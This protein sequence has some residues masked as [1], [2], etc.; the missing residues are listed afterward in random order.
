MDN[1][2][3]LAR[4]ALVAGGA[5]AA[6]AGHGDAALWEAVTGGALAAGGAV[7]SYIARR[8]ALATVPPG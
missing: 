1:V 7:W 5:A 3:W 2:F 4:M 6:S 8:K